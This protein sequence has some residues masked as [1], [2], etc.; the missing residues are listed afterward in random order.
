M[1]E[2]I[3][4]I[5]ELSGFGEHQEAVGKPS[6]N[7]ELELVFFRQYNAHPLSIGFAV[8]SQVNRDVEHFTADHSHQFTLREGLLTMKASQN[9]LLGFGL[10]ILYEGDVDAAFFELVFIIRLHEITSLIAKD[11]RFYDVDAFNL[12]LVEFEFSHLLSL[13]QRYRFIDWHTC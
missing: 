13:H 5:R 2:L 8:F 3:A 7:E 6:G 9:T 1:I 11:G 12:R 4:F 10:I